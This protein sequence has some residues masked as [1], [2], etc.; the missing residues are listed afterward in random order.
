MEKKTLIINLIGAPGTGKSTLMAQIF[1][2]LKWKSID[3]EMV[4]EFAKELVWA[5]R[6]KTFK[7]EMY[8]FSKQNHKLFMVNG[9]VDVIIT[10]RPL[11]LT[12]PYSRK[13][14]NKEFPEYYKALE[15]MVIETHNLYNNVNIMLER[16]KPY[17]PNGRNQSEEEAKELATLFEDCLN[18][19]GIPYNK[20]SALPSLAELI[21]ENIEEH[22]KIKQ[23]Y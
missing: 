21:V 16:V 20:Y 8:I 11:M 4:S 14:G 17:N 13:Y 1:A 2:L 9:Q 15:K 22:L 23:N 7:D 12:I 10:D 6:K 18:E 3:C 5:D 19:F